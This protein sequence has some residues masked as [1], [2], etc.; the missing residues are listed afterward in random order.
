MKKLFASEERNKFR[1]SPSPSYAVV[2]ACSQ[3][4]VRLERFEFGKWEEARLIKFVAS[5]PRMCLISCKNVILKM[6]IW[7]ITQFNLDTKLVR[8][9]ECVT[10][11]GVWEGCI[12]ATYGSGIFRIFHLQTKQLLARV[13]AHSRWIGSMDLLAHQGLFMTVSEDDVVAIWRL[14]MDQGDHSL[15]SKSFGGSIKK[16]LKSKIKSI[17]GSK[18]VKSKVREGFV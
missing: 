2:G 1:T 12:V 17:Q 8:V 3:L 16:K 5:K 4:G 13:A 10:G 9:E 14:K 7:P 18:G 6:S 15:N 11:L